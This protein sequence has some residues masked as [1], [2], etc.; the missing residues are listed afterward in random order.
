MHVVLVE[1]L[2]AFKM[3]QRLINYLLISFTFFSISFASKAQLSSKEKF[4]EALYLMDEKRFSEA[5][6]LLTNLIK[7]DSDN[8]NLNYNL[9][10]ALLNSFDEKGKKDALPYLE[11]AVKNVSPNYT[12]YS[13]R[14]KKAP[15]DAWYYLGMAQH[16]D[17]QF[18]EAQ[19]SF[20]KFRNYINEKHYLWKDIDKQIK[21]SNYAQIAIQNPV[22]IKT[23]NLG[24]K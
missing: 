12:P 23:T 22:N 24:G 21:M 4:T 1:K 2:Y 11:K 3:N 14:E 7:T 19:E 13:P 9:G 18:L 8:A 17:Y 6:P 16:N 10:V 20:S 15:V 5:L